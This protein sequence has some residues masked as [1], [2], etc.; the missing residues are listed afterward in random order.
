MQ[1]NG[2]TDELRHGG[3]NDCVLNVIVLD[4]DF[5]HLN[6]WTLK[7]FYNSCGREHFMFLDF[8]HNLMNSR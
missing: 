8:I 1:D 2:I 5:I 6:I 7:I 3:T 4:S